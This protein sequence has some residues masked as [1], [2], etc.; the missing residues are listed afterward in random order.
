MDSQGFVLLDVIAGFK[1]LQHMTTDLH[2]L[3]FVCQQ[4]PNI[5]YR[6]GVD[7]KS[8][9]RKMEGWKD[10][11][12][13]KPQRD[14]GSQHDGVE[15]VQIPAAPY[16]GMMEQQMYNNAARQSSLPQPLGSPNYGM[17]SSGQVYPPQYF[18]PTHGEVPAAQ[19]FQPSP[20]P[21]NHTYINHRQSDSGRVPNGVIPHNGIPT[22]GTAQHDSDVVSDSQVDKLVIMT[23]VPAT[24]SS[25]HETSNGMVDGKGQQQSS[26]AAD[27]IQGLNGTLLSHE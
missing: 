19:R 1:R 3:T 18:S 2:L 21:L 11:I 13:E 14:P 6:L 4:S 7:G 27:L 12:L 20:P 25:D 22:N 16:P 5:E 23:R 10:W 8:R 24:S 26:K 9:V 15:P 17:H